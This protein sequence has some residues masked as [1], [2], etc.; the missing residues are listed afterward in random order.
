MDTEAWRILADLLDL[1]SQVFSNHGSNDY[2]LDNT[3]GNFAVLE[4]MERDNVAGSGE[5][6]YPVMVSPDGK[7]LW[8]NDAALMGYFS[9]L[10]RELSS[11]PPAPRQAG[12]T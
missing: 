12:E 5:A 3:P 8:T 11:Q 6:P 2:E 4:A 7:K 9:K 1:A 10:A